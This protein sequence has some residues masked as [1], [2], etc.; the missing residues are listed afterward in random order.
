MTKK[1]YLQDFIIEDLQY[2]MVFVGGPR[3]VGKT[4]LARDVGEEK[5]KN[6][7]Y[8][9]WDNSED[10]IAIMKNSF[11]TE[12]PLIVF[13]EI[14]KY[15]RW[16]NYIKGQF[17][18]N[19]EKYNILVTGSA[20]LDTYRRGGDSMQGRYHYYR[21]HPF[22]LREVLEK[23][24]CLKINEKLDFLPANKETEKIKNDLLFYGGFPEPFIKKEEKVLRRFHKERVERLISG[25]IRDMELI[26]DLSAIQI[27]VELLP[28]KVG[29]LFSANSLKEDLQITNKTAIEWID[30]LE[31]FYYHFRIFPFASTHIKS[32]RRQ[33]K[34]YLWDWSQVKNDGA[35][36]EN[37]VASHLLKFVHL[38]QD[39]EGYKAELYFLRDIEMKETDFLVT[40][41]RKPWFAVEVKS[42][43]M[44]ISNNLRYFG[45]KLK[46][47]FLYQTV[48]Q[49]GVD[50][51]NGEVRLMSIDKFLSGLV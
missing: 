42:A 6:Y 17:D 46:I 20:R 5:Y 22:S 39:A 14:H 10:R 32:L 34:M 36:L 38:L 1:R 40:I 29:S 18:V 24:P 31:R 7:T 12:R 4:T 11:S 3:Q 44:A 33:P 30:V 51:Y 21:L 26:R 19:K 47:P 35:R 9:N 13:D 49:S 28:E 41:D 45:K 48:S 16:K 8:L 37:M 43:D 25:D 27:L 23:K 50:K 2:K 15:R